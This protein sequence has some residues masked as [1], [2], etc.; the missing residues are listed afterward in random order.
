MVSGSAIITAAPA[1]EKCTFCP[2]SCKS[3][4]GSWPCRTSE[5]C[6]PAKGNT[7][8]NY[9]KIDSDYLDYLTERSKLKI[10]KFTPGTHIPIYDDAKFIK[11]NPDY[12]LILA[13][14]FSK[15]IISNNKEYLD[16]GGKFIIQVPHPKIITKENFQS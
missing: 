8:L 10:G 13:W 14:N 16:N 2:L 3:Y 5:C 1:V 4:L 12:A 15:E 11:D 9:C 6:A 7:L